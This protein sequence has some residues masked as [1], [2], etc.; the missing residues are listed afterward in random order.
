MVSIN[1]ELCYLMKL[2]TGPVGAF[3]TAQYRIWLINSRPSPCPVNG[4]SCVSIPYCVSWMKI[5]SFYLVKN[6]WT[7]AIAGNTPHVSPDQQFRSLIRTSVLLALYDHVA[8]KISLKVSTGNIFY[9]IRLIK[10]IS[11]LL[12][13]AIVII[14]YQR[15]N[16]VLPGWR[17]EWNVSVGS[18]ATIRHKREKNKS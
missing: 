2:P 4:T 18:K 17:W 7:P 6:R 15:N 9:F 10:A 1:H 12:V 13:P 5:D 8:L 16:K 14:S 3:S 11:L